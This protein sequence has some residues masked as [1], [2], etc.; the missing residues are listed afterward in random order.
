MDAFKVWV[1]LLRHG[2]DG[3]AQLYDHLCAVT[4]FA[5]ELI[6]D[7]PDFEAIHEPECNIICFRFLGDGSLRDTQL[8]ELNRQLRERYNRSGE[9]WIT[10]TTLDGRRVLRMT[11]MNPRTT[12]AD[13]R[14]VVDGLARAGQDLIKGL[15]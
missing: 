5:W 3:F 4:R 13:I 12:N 10:A 6:D 8:D 9:G 11:V 15:S 7:R 14:A 1:A 2:T